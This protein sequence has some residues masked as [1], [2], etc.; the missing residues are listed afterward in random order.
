MLLVMIVIAIAVYVVMNPSILESLINILILVVVA[1]L[2]VAL[3]IFLAMSVLAVPYY[4]LK[5]E[6]F[7]TDASYDLK[8][9]KPVKEKTEIADATQG[10][11]KGSD[12]DDEDLK[13]LY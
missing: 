13:G 2:V 7:Q 6:K 10:K 11:E 8:D 1:I 5:G 9:V 4:V 3:I 12:R